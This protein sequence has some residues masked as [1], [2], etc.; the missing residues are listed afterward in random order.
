MATTP[1]LAVLAASAYYTQRSDENRIYAP[2]TWTLLDRT[3]NDSTGFEAVAYRKGN[4]VVIAFAGTD[5]Q[6]DWYT[7]VG[8]GLGF[9]GL[10]RCTHFLPT[11]DTPCP[12]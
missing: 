7:N 4:E 11:S 12:A 6:L 1:D 8:M 3:S 10:S 2:S 9:F 5:Q